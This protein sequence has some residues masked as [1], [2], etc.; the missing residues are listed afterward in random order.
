[1][2]AKTLD[3]L[4]VGFLVVEDGLDDHVLISV[5]DILRSTLDR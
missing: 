2:P 1:M 5:V 4:N 3:L